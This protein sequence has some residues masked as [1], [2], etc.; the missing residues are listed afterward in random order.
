MN[1]THALPERPP[2][3]SGLVGPT[4]LIGLGILFLL[5]NLGVLSWAI[6][7]E[8]VR[9]WPLLLIAVGLDLLFGRRSALGSLLAALLVLAALAAAIWWSNGWLGVGSPLSSQSLSQP[10][11]G[12]KRARVDIAMGMGE[13]RLGAQSESDGLISGTVAHGSRDQIQRDFTISS[14][15][16]TFKLHAVRQTGWSTPLRIGNKNELVWDLR[17]NPEIPLQL[18]LSTGAGTAVL[19]L[20]RLNVTSLNVSTGVGTTTLNLSQR[21]SLQANVSGGVGDTTITIPAGVA[22]RISASTGL[23]QVR[24]TGNF[25]RQDNL[26]VSPNYASATDRLDLAIHAGIGSVTVVQDLG[27]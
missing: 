6:W 9:L 16:A 23:G 26:Y 22:A 19:D 5:N 10:L 15:T 4:L 11:N 24:I 14:D 20:A 21:G 27:R 25:Q 8:I 7:P 3:R 13:L 12:A 17:L 18:D 1:T 2:R